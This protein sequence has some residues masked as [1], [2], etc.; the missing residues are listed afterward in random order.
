MIMRGYQR[1]LERLKQLVVSRLLELTKLNMS[2]VGYKQREKISQALRARAKAIQ[3]ALDSYNKAAR[4]MDPPRPSLE[5]K[6]V[7][8]MVTLAD[9]DL[10]KDMHLDLT[11]VPWAQPHHQECMRLYFGLKRA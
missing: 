8:D 6:S 11:N 9:F 10:L 5:W 1:T 3:K 7:L 4:A 2:G